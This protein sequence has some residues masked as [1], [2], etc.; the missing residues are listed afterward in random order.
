MSLDQLTAAEALALHRR[1]AAEALARHGFDLE[2]LNSFFNNADVTR[3]DRL[4]AFVELDRAT[5]AYR[6][7]EVAHAMEI[8]RVL[9]MVRHIYERLVPLAKK[10][11]K[12]APSGRGAGTIRK[13]IAAH[14]KRHPA[15]KP[16]DVWSAIAAK[17]PKGWQPRDNRLGRYFEGPGNACVALGRFRNICSEEKKRLKG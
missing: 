3:D 4:N 17:P 8:L 1:L 7:G 5:T 2:G 12:F 15:A 6:R 16:D 9:F 13:A 10:G 14:L 11:L